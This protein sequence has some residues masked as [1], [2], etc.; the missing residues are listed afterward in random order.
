MGHRPA[1]GRVNQAERIDRARM[2]VILAAPFFG[3]LLMRMPM[4]RDDRKQT[5]CTD[6]KTIAYNDAYAAT[7]DDAQLRY[8]LA[9]EVLH[10]ALGHLWRCGERDMEKWNE[11]AD[12]TV[13]EMLDAYAAED[14][15]AAPDPSRY[16]PPWKAFRGALINPAFFGL[17][18][19]TIYARLPKN[20][21]K[22]KADCG[23]KDSDSPQSAIGNPQ[24][25]PSPGEFEKG[26]DDGADGE[27][28]EFS[29]DEWKLAVTQAATIARMQ[30]KLPGSIARLV[31]ELLAPKV[32]WRDVLREFIRVL[33][34]DDYC[35]SRP[36]RRYAHTGFMLPSLHSERMGRLAIGVDTSGSIDD[37]I[38]RVFASEIQA[39]L[40]ECQPERID[41][42]YCDARVQ[43]TEEYVPGDAVTLKNC[44][45]GGGTKFE[46]VFQHIEDFEEPPVA[47]IYLTDLEGSFPAHAPDYPVL[48]A[49]IKNRPYPFG[50][51]VSV[52]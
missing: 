48:W 46:P 43:S 42:I 18:A 16:V 4:V 17:D 49:S 1:G 19:E 50:E 31:R 29:E 52:Q 5:F 15:A 39:A 34:K 33:A 24:S 9:H 13:N 2:D 8:I 10:P 44:K 32:P 27:G 3:S 22:R 35:W 20:C 28:E 30:G 12:Y 41:V 51:V 21:G 14:R 45:G 7:L 11:A 25:A 38:L 47:L 37:E 26:A 40:D 36:N 6:G 23:K